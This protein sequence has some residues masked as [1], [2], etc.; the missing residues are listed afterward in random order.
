MSDKAFRTFSRRAVTAGLALAP[1]GARAQDYPQ[2]VIRFV[3]PFAAF[4]WIAFA[5]TSSRSKFSF[6]YCETN[7]GSL[8]LMTPQ[9]H[10]DVVVDQL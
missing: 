2:G 4:C 1:F 10:L 5:A 8:A 3:C 7:V 9:S 6:A